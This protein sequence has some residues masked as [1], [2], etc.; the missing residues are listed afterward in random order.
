MEIRQEMD[1]EN[2]NIDPYEILGVPFGASIEVCK[3][4]Y[5]SLSKIYIVGT[6]VKT[7]LK[8]QVT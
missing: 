4:T 5:K 7:A 3:A 1:F 6:V 2:D 8:T